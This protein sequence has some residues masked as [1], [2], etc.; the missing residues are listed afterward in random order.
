MIRNDAV[1]DEIRECSVAIE[2]DSWEAWP[3]AIKCYLREISHKRLLK[4]DEEISLGR[5]ARQGDPEARRR[6]I[7]C[8][9]RLVVRSAR[10]YINRGLPLLDLIQEG[11]IGLIRAV[12]KFDPDKGFRFSTY[13][14]WWIR[15]G[16]ERALMEQTRTV[17]IPKHVVKNISAVLRTSRQLEQKLRREPSAEE[18]AESLGWSVKQVR[19]CLDID[20]HCSSLQTAR[21]QENDLG[22]TELGHDLDVPG[23]EGYIAQDDLRK[24]LYRWI[25]A[26]DEK[27]RLVL[28][29]RYGLD[30]HNETTSKDIG[31]HLGLSRQSVRHKQAQGMLH[32]RAS[33]LSEGLDQHDL[34]SH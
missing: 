26:L 25:G 2:R 31:S 12:E 4:V 17:R 19:Y 23:P 29:W 34:F 20:N 1:N 13:A 9:L 5:R 28:Y 6:M 33:I 27:Q 14:T 7:E 18:M 15:E 30:G 21:V 16:M 32:L 3:D 22:M 10:R 8:N 11:N 24:S